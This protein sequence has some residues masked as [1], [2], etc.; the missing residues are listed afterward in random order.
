MTSPPHPANTAPR[1]AAAVGLCTMQVPGR[2]AV[3]SHAAS[4]AHQ[5]PWCVVLRQAHKR[6]TAAAPSSPPQRLRGGHRLHSYQQG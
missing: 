6:P 5:P 1:G 4:R 3:F 2:P